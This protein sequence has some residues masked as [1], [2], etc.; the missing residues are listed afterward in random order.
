MSALLARQSDPFRAVILEIVNTGHTLDPY[1]DR[2]QSQ[3]LEVISPNNYADA[4][5]I[6]HTYWR[7]LVVIY[8]APE[9]KIDARTWIEIQHTDRMLRLATT[10]LLVL[11]DA[12]RVP[13]LRIDQLPDRVVIVPRRADTL[14]QLSRSVKRLLT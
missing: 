3:G 6:A 7:V 5:K 2:L 10:P 13:L 11:A 12:S 9:T 1:S 4:L 14:N 8:E